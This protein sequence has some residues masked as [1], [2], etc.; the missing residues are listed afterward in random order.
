MSEA[1]LISRIKEMKCG[2]KTI[3]QEY[4]DCFNDYIEKVINTRVDEEIAVNF[5]A[6][7]F[8]TA[9]DLVYAYKNLEKAFTKSRQK[10]ADLEAK[11]A[12]SKEQLIAMNEKSNK[13]KKESYHIKQQLKESEKF[14]QANGFKNWK[15]A[16]DALNGKFE[17]I[18]DEKQ[19][20]WKKIVAENAQLKQQ[21]AEKDKEVQKWKNKKVKYIVDNII[22]DRNQTAIDELEKVRSKIARLDVSPDESN[23][24]IPALD[25][26]TNGFHKSRFKIV[27]ILDQQ[28]KSLK[29]EK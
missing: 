24:L 4:I 21:L 12:E 17:C 29:G 18:F 13:I 28:I 19:E 10:L 22:C 3:P 27:N 26:Y 15:E 7:K 1:V 11:L 2:S 23:R 16:Q 8:K 20:L 14:M 9:K 5:E 25:N 6:G